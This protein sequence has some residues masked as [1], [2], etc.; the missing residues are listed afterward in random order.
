MA[1][2]AEQFASTFNFKSFT[3]AVELKR[4]LWFTL[5]AIMIFR[6]GTYIPLPGIDPHIWQEIFQQKSGGVLDMFN[7]FSGGALRSE[8]HTSELQSQR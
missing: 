3:K 1:S 4:R 8:E 5:W 7:M 2:A 6:A